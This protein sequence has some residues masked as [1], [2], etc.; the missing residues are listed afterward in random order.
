MVVLDHEWCW[1]QRLR[2]KTSWE[3]QQILKGLALAPA[4]NQKALRFQSNRSQGGALCPSTSYRNL[5]WFLKCENNYGLYRPVELAEA[6]LRNI[7]WFPVCSHMQ[8]LVSDLSKMYSLLSWQ[9]LNVAFFWLCTIF[10][11]SCILFFHYHSLSVTAVSNISRGYCPLF[12]Q[13]I[14]NCVWLFNDL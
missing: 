13:H 11:Q 12:Y 5:W 10:S 7:I 8:L 4:W 9:S 14:P 6:V 3:I 1:Y 2:V